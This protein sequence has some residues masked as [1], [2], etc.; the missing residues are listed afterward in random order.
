[1]T[2]TS[3][4]IFCSV[5]LTEKDNRMRELQDVFAQ[6]RSAERIDGGVVMT[7]DPGLGQ[8]VANLVAKEAQCCGFL[9]MVTETSVGELRLEVT[10]DEHSAV[11]AIEAF[12]GL[13][14]LP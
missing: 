7:F 11:P 10:T 13:D 9:S 6:A 4:P 12:I 14:R 1:M 5:P 8:D 2:H 3:T